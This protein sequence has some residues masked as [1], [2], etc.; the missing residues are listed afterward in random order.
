MN[1]T[2]TLFSTPTLIFFV[3]STGCRISS[4]FVNMLSN[5]LSKE[6]RQHLEYHCF[7][8]LPPDN[9]EYGRSTQLCYRDLIAFLQETHR[10]F[11]ETRVPKNLGK[12]LL[13]NS[14]QGNGI[15]RIFGAISLVNNL[16]Q[17][18]DIFPGMIER[19]KEGDSDVSQR[20]QIYIVSAS[21]GG[22][23]GGQILDLVAILYDYFKR[24]YGE[25]PNIFP[26][27]LGP[28]AL[29]HDSN[30]D[31]SLIAN[32]LKASD[33]ALNK[34]IYHFASG[35]PFETFYSSVYH[36]IQIN[37]KPGENMLSWIYY[38]NSKGNNNNERLTMENIETR[39]AEILI[40]L[41]CSKIGKILHAQMPNQREIFS[42][43]F[44]ADF[45]H[46][47][48]K[49]SMTPEEQKNIARVSRNTI[50]AGFNI[51]HVRLCLPEIHN[52]FIV[53]SQ[54]QCIIALLNSKSSNKFSLEEI[55]EC[56]GIFSYKNTSSGFIHQWQ[57]DSEFLNV[58]IL[59]LIN[60]EMLTV[61]PPSKNIHPDKILKNITQ[62]LDEL[63]D[64]IQRLTIRS[65]SII[66]ENI[67]KIL[68]D[69]YLHLKKALLKNGYI[70]ND[71]NELSF[72]PIKGKGIL[73]SKTLIEQ[74]ILYAEERA[75]N[76]KKISVNTEIFDD[77]EKIETRLKTI[78][79]ECEK[80]KSAL[81]GIF[82]IYTRK[83]TG[84]KNPNPYNFKTLKKIESLRKHVIN[85]KNN[86]SDLLLNH[87][88]SQLSSLY[89]QQQSELFKKYKKEFLDPLIQ[90]LYSAL[91]TAKQNEKNC[92]N[93][94]KIY[95]KKEI[96]FHHVKQIGYDKE[97]INKLR[98]RLPNI[99]TIIENYLDK[100]NGNGIIAGK[101]QLKINEFPKVS[102]DKLLNV[103]KYYISETFVQYNSFLDEGWQLDEVSHLYDKAAKFL[104]KMGGYPLL[105]YDSSGVRNK[106][107]RFLIIPQNI[108][109][110]EPFGRE[111]ATAER[112]A[113][114]N[115]LILSVVSF[116]YGVAH[117]NLL[118]IHDYYEQYTN[119]ICDSLEPS[120]DQDPNRC[121]LHTFK[122]AW[123]WNEIHC[124]PE[125]CQNKEDIEKLI[126]LSRKL[127][128]FNGNNKVILNNREI[129]TNNVDDW[130][131]ANDFQDALIELNE[132]I[133]KTMLMDKKSA[134]IGKSYFMASKS[135]N[136]MYQLYNQRASIQ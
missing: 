20:I 48:S 35:N 4:L 82:R 11:C 125:Y 72:C 87:L 112:I 66:P 2:K 105:N 14:K 92:I 50:L 58:K 12:T 124:P 6:Q 70:Y 121:P 75:A 26:I 52:Y 111:I 97:T 93:K 113:G 30:K 80:Q 129:I 16:D 53:L 29:I 32:K 74:L 77:I 10:K 18:I 133:L 136:S 59:N 104:D 57:L 119:Y 78:H 47:D 7:D 122:D 65:T 27:L 107:T 96:K 100:L 46:P 102:P 134:E 9:I 67:K 28:D 86:I 31:V 61:R 1:V 56:L 110:P 108:Q 116:I 127:N 95:Q 33:Y 115:S 39:V 49:W 36:K 94:M 21:F 55:Y 17:V 83:W 103:T 99:Q 101:E 23:G 60:D 24:K 118:H 90:C 42:K 85:L 123:S 132:R 130:M 64:I 81:T 5:L 68:T 44:P 25:S 91:S 15:T 135:L 62:T 69:E 34:E 38:V 120:D 114:K 3:G 19:L 98:K 43:K 76:I 126:Q 128:I 106:I 89:Y 8:S 84:S 79:K 22:T 40:H 131:K 13:I 71:L 54:K 117:N 51:Q 73:F 63:K 88:F 109:L 37:N 45:K 41:T